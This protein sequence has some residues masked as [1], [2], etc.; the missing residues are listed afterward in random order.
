MGWRRGAEGPSWGVL[1]HVGT[2]STRLD[3]T[4]V[5]TG[6][7]W[8]LEAHLAVGGLTDGGGRGGDIAYLR[9]TRVG[10]R[11]ASP[12]SPDVSSSRRSRRERF[13]WQDFGLR[14]DVASLGLEAGRAG[15]GAGP[16]RSGEG[17]RAEPTGRD[18]G[19]APL[20]RGDR[21][22]GGDD[23]ETEAE[24]GDRRY[25]WAQTGGQ[26]AG[27]QLLPGTT[28]SQISPAP[29]QAAGLMGGQLL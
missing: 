2:P 18:P 26:A 15:A 5:R 1:E 12:G 24:E 19:W 11:L 13:N 3:G 4:K 25:S 7:A 22:R 6:C 29:P 14:T 28:P 21:T 20:K 8:T 27:G 10:S 17:E 16:G 23:W 9:P